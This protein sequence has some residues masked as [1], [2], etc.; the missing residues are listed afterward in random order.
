MDQEAQRGRRFRLAAAAADAD[1][2][3]L[4]PAGNQPGLPL[5][6]HLRGMKSPQPA[7]EGRA[8]FLWK[9]EHE[10]LA[11]EKVGPD[12]KQLTRRPVGLLDHAVAVGDQVAVGGQL[13]ELL[14]AQPLAPG[15]LRELDA[16]GPGAL[17]L[18]RR[19][20]QLFDRGLELLHRAR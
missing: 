15:F 3:S 9:E 6:N 8:I 16:P 12:A 19:Y 5:G 17:Q 20:G 13:E 4:A 7:V 1:R 18:L 14:V 2:A 11:V 10:R